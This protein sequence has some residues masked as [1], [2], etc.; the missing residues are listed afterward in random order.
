MKE[1][2]LELE[3]G[4]FAL[5]LDTTLDFFFLTPTLFS[6]PDGSPMFEPRA[7][8]APL[9]RLR[10]ETARLAA[11]DP[12]HPGLLLYATDPTA[13]L[14]GPGALV[15]QPQPEESTDLALRDA[16]RPAIPPG[17][18]HISR[19]KFTCVRPVS[20]HGAA[21]RWRDDWLL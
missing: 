4:A 10:T 8:D 9:V 12:F 6:R 20:L 13:A 2:S 5:M 1:R 17:H 19:A 11:R 3:P 14:T 18:K 16:F 7:R 15:D 21:A